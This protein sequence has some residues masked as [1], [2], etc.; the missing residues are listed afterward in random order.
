M[1]DQ[2][3]SVTEDTSDPAVRRLFVKGRVTS[4]TAD[5]LQYSLDEAVGEGKGRVVV[6]MQS[7]LFLSS[8][9]IRILLMC[10]KKAKGGG[11]SFFV[12]RPSE[13]VKNVLGMTALDELLL[14]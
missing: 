5:V 11:G 9:G 13:N 4:T 7:V 3:F 12:E 8:A 6:N 1:S 14:K 2:E 10:L